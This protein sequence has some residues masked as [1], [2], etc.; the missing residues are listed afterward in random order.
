M[1]KQRHKWNNRKPIRGPILWMKMAMVFVTTSDKEKDAG[2]MD[3]VEAM[4]LAVE[5][6]KE[7]VRDKELPLL[8]KMAMVF[9][10]TSMGA[11]MVRGD[12]VDAE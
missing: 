4:G 6:D 5:E 7:E 11:E 8:I 10:I 12:E 1:S 3:K 2:G 9:V